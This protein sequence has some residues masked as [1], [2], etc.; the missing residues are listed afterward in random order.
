MVQ[1]KYVIKKIKSKL[2]SFFEFCF[3]IYLN[4]NN[5]LCFYCLLFSK[6]SRESKIYNKIQPS[7][8]PPAT[9]PNDVK[10]NVELKVYYPLLIHT[11]FPR[12]SQ[13]LVLQKIKQQRVSNLFCAQI[14][15]ESI[16]NIVVA[17]FH[18][19][20]NIKKVIDI[21]NGIQS[22]FGS[23]EGQQELTQQLS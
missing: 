15:C 22:K 21:V 3:I 19:V 1:V 9:T 11:Y 18:T 4:H 5:L 12:I 2:T 7:K 17:S 8:F 14:N 13:N 20:Y 6:P 10:A 16:H 23:I